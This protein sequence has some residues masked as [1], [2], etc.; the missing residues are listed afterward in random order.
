MLKYLFQYKFSIFLAGFI[1]LLSL[2]PDS[3]IPDSSLFSISYLDK[4]V[5]A[6]M[7]GSFGFVALLEHRS[8]SPR[9]NVQ[10]L[11]L[12]VIFSISAVIEVLQATVVASR[13]AEWM[14]LLANLSGLLLGYL[15]YRLVRSLRF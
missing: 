2:L 10:L 11:L 15:A 7:Y 12:L 8:R 5:H 14:D 6:G 13:S 4:M 1:A 9:I 3:S